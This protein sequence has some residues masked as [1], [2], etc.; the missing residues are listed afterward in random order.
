[1]KI[2][3]HVRLCVCIRPRDFYFSGPEYIIL[4]IARRLVLRVA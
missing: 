2:Q 1:M 4:Y 3:G